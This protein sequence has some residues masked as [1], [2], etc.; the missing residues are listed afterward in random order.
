[1]GIAD[2]YKEGAS[3]WGSFL[4]AFLASVLLLYCPGYLV[5]RGLG[6][7]RFAG[8]ACAPLATLVVCSIATIAF[9]K[10]GLFCAWYLLLSVTVLL[11]FFVYLAGNRVNAFRA[12]GISNL[13]SRNLTRSSSVSLEKKGVA[14]I[15]PV[16]YVLFAALIYC[17]MFVVNVDDASS[18]VQYYDN[19]HHINSIQGFLLSGNWSSFD[20]EVYP[21][22]SNGEIAP[23]SSSFGFYP[24]AWHCVAAFAASLTGCSVP[25][26][27]NAS[28]A[29]FVVVVFP[30][31][32]CLML[33]KLFADKPLVCLFGAL[34]VPACAFYPWRLITFGPLYPNIA[35]MS[36]IP[37]A[38]YLFFMIM[39]EGITRPQ[40]VIRVATFVMALGSMAFSQPNTL[41]T[42]GLF[43]APYLVVLFSKLP[44]RW[45]DNRLR[46][47]IFAGLAATITMIVL[48]LI[49]YK[50]PPLQPVIQYSWPSYTNAARAFGDVVHT[51]YLH[52]PGQLALSIAASVGI[53]AA[54]IDKRR[55]WLVL[56]F[57]LASVIYMVVA[58]SDEGIRHV[59][60]GFWYTDPNRIIA[61]LMIFMMP[62]VSWGLASSAYFLG[63]IIRYIGGDFSKS[64]LCCPAILPACSIIV[65]LFFAI[66]NYWPNYLIT[67]QVCKEN[68]FDVAGMY[69]RDAFQDSNNAFFDHQE[70]SFVKEAQAI[71]D[72]D[73]GIAN[74]PND[75]SVS[76]FGASGANVVYRFYKEADSPD[77]LGSSVIVRTKLNEIAESEEVKQAVRD[78]NIEYVL[79][80][81][82]GSHG[83]VGFCGIY[84]DADKWR[85]IDD[86]KDDT[87]GFELMLADDDMRLYRILA[88]D[89]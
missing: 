53:V 79:I 9:H 24:S 47:R 67:G 63:R 39:E 8:L 46:S 45:H 73:K 43:L 16:L 3:M 13:K 5:F 23:V 62:L 20:I 30:L 41:F 33:A 52:H 56:S 27:E 40:R 51:R 72:P 66:W 75:G 50:L 77:E 68:A 80:L 19:M 83:G 38:A 55:F 37:G 21:N 11:G 86:I 44:A 28:V 88:A 14:A 22:A 70:R 87:P 82:R 59:L 26:A 74:N 42:L 85:G 18:F 84:N 2:H 4:L 31:G 17:F 10:M 69:M 61:F 54:I 65:A 49:C 58:F 78:L 1:M 15:C 89:D 12:P 81:D 48:W 34:V 60:A 64:D 7:G 25:I 35:S 32:M 6:F 29:V 36:L 71:V 57:A 76:A